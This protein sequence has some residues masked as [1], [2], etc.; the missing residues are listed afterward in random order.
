MTAKEQ[1]IRDIR[2]SLKEEGKCFFH[3]IKELDPIMDQ[4]I[5]EYS[6]EQQ[7]LGDRA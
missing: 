2:E 1:A 6:Q 7:Q 4:I 3:F 5:D